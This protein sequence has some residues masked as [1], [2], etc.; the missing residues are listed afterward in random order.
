MIEQVGMKDR[1]CIGRDVDALGSAAR[2]MKGDKLFVDQIQ[3]VCRI[4][5]RR[6]MPTLVG[7][8][9]HGEMICRTDGAGRQLS[10]QKAGHIG[11]LRVARF[12]RNAHCGERNGG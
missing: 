5:R 11:V 2:K 8:A 7:K 3:A 6:H 12:D 4:Q 9:I 10:G 1:L